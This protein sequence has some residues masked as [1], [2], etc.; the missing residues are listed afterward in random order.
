IRTREKHVEQC[1]SAAL[2]CLRAGGMVVN[3]T[4]H[5]APL[6]AGINGNSTPQ[7]VVQL[8]FSARPWHAAACLLC[9]RTI[10]VSVSSTPYPA[11]SWATLYRNYPFLSQPTGRGTLP[12]PASGGLRTQTFNVPKD[13]IMQVIARLSAFVG[14]TFAIWVLLFAFLAFF[15]PDHYTWIAPYI[16]PLLGIIMFGMGLTLSKD[17]FAEVFK[18]PRLVMIGVL[19]QFIIM[20]ALAW[21]LCTVLQLPPEIAV[22]VI[23]VGCC[24]GGT[25]S[26]V[27]TSLARGDIALSVAITSVTT[28]LAPLVTPALIYLLASQWIDVSAAAMF[29]SIVQ[30]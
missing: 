8:G 25:A 17:D 3:G 5:P 14:K 15:F 26:S 24:P 16:V 20:P 2:C 27:M 22:V 21:V 18:R 30:V 12:R 28:L 29:W 1:G 10:C 9:R 19:G 7:F 23:L 13:I 6:S 11:L 4:G